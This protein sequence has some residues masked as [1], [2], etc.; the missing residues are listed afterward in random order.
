MKKLK[1][2]V[3]E[4]PANVEVDLKNRLEEMGFEVVDILSN[5]EDLIQTL[6][7]RRADIVLTDT[8]ASSESTGFDVEEIIR[9]KYMT[10]VVFLSSENSLEI[11]DQVLETGA[12]CL[13]SKPAR[14]LD[15]KTNLILA[16]ERFSAENRAK[17]TASKPDFKEYIFVRADYKIVK[18][19]V[20]DIFFIEAK[21][22]YITINTSDN[23]FTVHS[24][25]KDIL[26]VLPLERFI[27]IHRGYIVNI[28]KIFS[29]KYP[30]LIIES[31]MKVLPVGGLYRKN[32]FDRLNI[33]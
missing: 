16:H 26:R 21:K 27:R 9:E 18:I 15:I 19:R 32:L 3:A 6:D 2:L 23:V 5:T 25:M 28:D 24:S 29:I 20:L 1:V 8:F 4:N 17:P 22:D 33:I 10:P 12:L 7:S 14:D 13:I 31:K 30:D 11:A